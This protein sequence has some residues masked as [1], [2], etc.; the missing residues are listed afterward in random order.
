MP[1][2]VLDPPPKGLHG[3]RCR[4]DVDD[5]DINLM[6][7]D[8]LVLFISR[9]NGLLWLTDSLDNESLPGIP[10]DS[11]GCIQLCG[12]D[13]QRIAKQWNAEHKPTRGAKK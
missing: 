10:L 7:N 9:N 4:L 2:F 3:L 13:R 12:A 6:I 5:G 11:A 1:K 8:E